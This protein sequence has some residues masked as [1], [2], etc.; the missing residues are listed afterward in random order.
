MTDQNSGEPTPAFGAA[1]DKPASTESEVKFGKDDLDKILKQNYHAQEHIKTLE[2]E[3]EAAKLKLQDL[4]SKL[5]SA[6]TIDDLLDNMQNMPQNNSPESTAPQFNQEAMISQ[7]KEEVFSELSQAQLK[8]VE[9]TNW[10]ESKKMAEERYGKEFASYV[11]TKATEMDLS[12][13][14]VEA[15]AKTS[16][17]AFMELLGGTGTP[18]AAPTTPGS[19]GVPSQSDDYDYA[20]IARLRTENSEEGRDAQKLWSSTGFQAGYR[21]SIIDKAKAHG[22]EFGN[23][24]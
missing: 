22:S 21:K 24:L 15:L 16:P 20:K 1:D 6:S 14:Q 11:D 2:T 4:E 8:A 13:E 12:N 7:L 23:R 3:S 5:A 17:K 10:E 18:S 9:D 19:T